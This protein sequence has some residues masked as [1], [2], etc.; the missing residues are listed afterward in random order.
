MGGIFKSMDAL[1]KALQT[2][3]YVALEE[4]AEQ[5]YMDLK[6]NVNFFYDSPEGRYKRTGQLKASPQL[7]SINYNGN[8]AIGQISINTG[9]QYDPAGRDTNTIYGYAESDGLIGN[10]GFWRATE[11]DIED[12]IAESFG[13]RFS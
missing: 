12:N 2:E 5:S 4:A 13:K 1:V 10:G 3:M 6:E 9:T 7:D 8:S 11:Y